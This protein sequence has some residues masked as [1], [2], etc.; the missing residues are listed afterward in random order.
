MKDSFRFR[1]K[2]VV[3]YASSWTQQLQQ[4]RTRNLK[5]WNSSAGQEQNK[6]QGFGRHLW[7]SS[8]STEEGS[9]NQGID[10]FVSG[11][12]QTL[13]LNGSQR[14]RRL[15]RTEEGHHPGF[16]RVLKGLGQRLLFVGILPVVEGHGGHSCGHVV[17]P[18]AVGHV[19]RSARTA[20]RAGG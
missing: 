8:I 9:H 6:S 13:L 4:N 1:L 18:A 17:R 15:L 2:L 20:S 5:E 11:F 19:F 16:S 3:S 7:I 10:R 14:H 12:R